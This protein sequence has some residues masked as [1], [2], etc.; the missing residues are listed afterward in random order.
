MIDDFVTPNFTLGEFIVSD[1]AVRLGIDNMPPA[2]VEANLRNVLIPGMQ[3]IRNL[4]AV[5]VVIK[6]GYRCHTLNLAVRGSP[7]SQH[8]TGNA[9]DFIA[10]AYG[11]PRK[12]SEL[13]TANMGRLKFDQLI[14]EGGWVHVSFAPRPRN[15]VL[16]AHF[17]AD[18][19]SYTQGLA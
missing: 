16:T 4:L 11:S 9:A 18:G 15:Q 14:W 6:S 12:V 17:R 19:V 1:T 13:L 3:A 7:S 8:V 10:P 5:P 2:Q